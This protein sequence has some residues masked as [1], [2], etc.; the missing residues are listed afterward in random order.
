MSPVKIK[1]DDLNSFSNCTWIP[2]KINTINSRL[3]AI[4][5][6]E[7][8]DKPEETGISTIDK[9]FPPSSTIRPG[10]TETNYI[11]CLQ[12]TSQF[13]LF[14]LEVLKG[15]II[16]KPLTTLIWKKQFTR[17]QKAQKF[18]SPYNN[19]IEG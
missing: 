10:M 18:L 5:V 14:T 19:D 2:K 1:P 15:H 9:Y 17:N 11:Y 13:S 12:I 16:F 8:V 3:H 6:Q 4:L 7:I